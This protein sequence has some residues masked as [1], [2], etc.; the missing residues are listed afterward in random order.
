MALSS[1]PLLANPEFR[2]KEP[3]GP[4]P[5]P[6]RTR[7][8]FKFSDPTVR[9]GEV[10]ESKGKAKDRKEEVQAGDINWNGDISGM[11]PFVSSRLS[12]SLPVSITAN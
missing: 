11:G 4:E 2:W 7:S 6:T 5:S 8:E 1:S 9:D 3:C 12:S 10:G